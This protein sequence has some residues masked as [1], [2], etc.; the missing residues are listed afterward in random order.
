M[1]TTKKTNKKS[2]ELHRVLFALT[3][4]G[5]VARVLLFS[6]LMLA[7]SAATIFLAGSPLELLQ[8]FV[9][10][11][12]GFLIFDAIYMTI[13]RLL[14]IAPVADLALLLAVELGY[15]SLV[16]SPI[17]ATLGGI[18]LIIILSPLFVMCLRVLLGVGMKQPAK[19]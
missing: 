17:F 13:V 16:V 5:T 3:Y 11:V 19:R 8:F 7:L 12:G 14:P 1:K 10:V 9:L 18:H 6:F 4:T 15:I 2:Y